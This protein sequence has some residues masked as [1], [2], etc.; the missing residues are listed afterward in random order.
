[1]DNADRGIREY[2]ITKDIII[3]TEKHVKD[4]MKLLSDLK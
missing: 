4:S 2:K 3:K 1:M